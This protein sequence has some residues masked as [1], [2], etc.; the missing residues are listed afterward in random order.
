MNVL[1]ATEGVRLYRRGAS[2]RCRT[3]PRPQARPG[4]FPR[5][6][7]WIA[8]LLLLGSLGLGLPYAA[9][10]KDLL[11]NLLAVP[12]SR[13]YLDSE[14]G[15]LLLRFDG[16]VF[17]AG[18][19]PLEVRGLRASTTDPMVAYQRIYHTHGGYRDVPM[20]GAQL[21]YAT[22]DGH[23]HWHLQKI[24]R[25][26]LWNRRRTRKVAP[27]MKVG[28]CLEDSDHF[29]P[30]VGPLGPVY[31]DTN[32]RAF[33]QH[34]NPG[35]LSVW[36]GISAGWRD[37]YKRS[38]PFQWVDVSNVE[39]GRY[40]LREDVDPNRIVIEA[41]TSRDP[42]KATAY[43]TSLT[44][45]PGYNAKSL[46]VRISSRSATAIE[47]QARRYGHTGPPRF[48]VDKPPAHGTLSVRA[49]QFFTNPNIT[50]R[51]R[52][53]YHGHDHFTYVAADTASRYPYRRI[54]AV[55]SLDH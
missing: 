28:F 21:V 19:G 14:K 34:D 53:G 50:Y 31:N 35:A 46:R 30:A 3:D 6:A 36:E 13:D 26:S 23:N 54:E 11:P 42:A 10:A 47:L 15:H 7:S 43:A 16:W 12:P 39:P 40:W 2:R 29:N 17:N 55:L 51:P 38:L 49:G 20:P 27:A 1:Q 44:T 37:L 8:G 25:Y 4:L 24:A 9:A 22:A 45:I 48:R 18:P 33:C 32:G 5:R 41:P 52:Q